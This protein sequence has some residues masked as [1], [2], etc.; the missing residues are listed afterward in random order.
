MKNRLF[1]ILIIGALM[2]LVSCHR[3]PITGR[4]QL[5]LVSESDVQSM[6]LVQ[7]AQFLSSNKV[8]PAGNSD[9]EMVK[10]VGSRIAD[11]ITRYYQQHGGTDALKDYKWEFNLVESKE[12]NAWCMPGGK[13][14]VYTGLLAVTQNETALAIVLGHEITHAVAGHGRERMSQLLLAQGIQVAGDIALQNNPQTANIF[15]QVY[16]PTA[17]VAV[18]LPYNRKQ[19]YE[20][21]HYGLIFAAMAGYDPQEAIPFW[22][23]MAA[24]GGQKPPVFLSDHPADEDRIQKLQELMP[25]ALKYYRAKH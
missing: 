4:N 11:A 22:R 13:V 7:Y 3:N 8:V 9:R 10:R 12:I 14:V 24:L 15:N 19:E 21:D 5:S 23:R 18:L 1:S 20:A 16:A 6:A 17:Q 2:V 25:E